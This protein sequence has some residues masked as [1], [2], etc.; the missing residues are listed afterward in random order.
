MFIYFDCSQCFDYWKKNSFG[1]LFPLPRKYFV[2]T[3]YYIHSYNDAFF[4]SP[5][6]LSWRRCFVPDDA[7]D[8]AKQAVAGF[9]FSYASFVHNLSCS[10]PVIV[11]GMQTQMNNFTAAKLHSLRKMRLQPRKRSRTTRSAWMRVLRAS[12]APF[13]NKQ[14][15]R[16]SALIL[17]CGSKNICVCGIFSSC[18]HACECVW[19]CFGWGF[20]SNRQRLSPS[21]STTYRLT[22]S[23]TECRTQIAWRTRPEISIILWRT[24]WS[25]T[26]C[27][28]KR[29]SKRSRIA[30]CVRRRVRVCCSKPHTHT[31]SHT[32]HKTHQWNRLPRAL[33][34]IIRI[35]ISEIKTYTDAPVIILS[36]P[37][38]L[39]G[40]VEND[41]PKLAAGRLR[42]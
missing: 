20:P 2:I 29:A 38:C 40:R 13:T 26:N 28:G 16:L 41:T 22:S 23:P 39:L 17:R 19:V 37:A 1:Y 4:C 9:L 33:A 15:N 7:R 14:K 12:D 8:D 24:T 6:S 3:E 5:L 36:S 32:T 31:H 11:G 27:D 10:A 18:F 42:A 25:V 30:D 21:P 35:Y 34:H